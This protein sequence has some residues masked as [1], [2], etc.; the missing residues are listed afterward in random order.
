LD[1]G[2]QTTVPRFQ[3][4]PQ[5]DD[6]KRVR[7]HA[8]TAFA[9]RK[10]DFEALP[11]DRF[12]LFNRQETEKR[13]LPMSWVVPELIKTWEIVR[14][15][16]KNKDSETHFVTVAEYDSPEKARKSQAF[17]RSGDKWPDRKYQNQP[18][19]TGVTGKLLRK[20]LGAELR[21]TRVTGGYD[22]RFPN[23]VI[24]LITVQASR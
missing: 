20:L 12:D 17:F 22:E 24:S 1:M 19:A 11:A 13:R 21:L 18:L 15:S 6:L 10:I 14:K 5:G 16:L 7:Q 8:A 4:I 9:D 2:L 23:G 3:G